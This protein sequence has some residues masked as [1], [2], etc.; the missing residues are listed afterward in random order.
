MTVF[1]VNDHDGTQLGIF[2]CDWFAR[3]SKRGGAWMSTFVDQAR[4]LGTRPVVVV[5]LNVP[6][7]PGDEPALMT[8]D[9]VRTAFHEFGHALHGLFSDVPTRGS[10]APTSRATSSSS[11]PRSTRCGRGGRRS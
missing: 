7:P 2:V 8:S 3:D 10:R 11:R 6:R 4:L 5:N 9:N 1:D